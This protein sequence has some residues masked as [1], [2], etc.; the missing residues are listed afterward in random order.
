MPQS[1]LS[2][3]RTVSP[4]ALVGLLCGENLRIE[5]YAGPLAYI[6]KIFMSRVGQD[7]EKIRIAARSA[8][9]FRR[10]ATSCLQHAG[11]L[12]SRFL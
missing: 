12:G 8:T 11:I 1:L 4:K 5:S 9:I 2:R 10:A 6:F 3:E 7:F